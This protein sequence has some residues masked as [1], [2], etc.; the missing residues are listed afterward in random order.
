MRDAYFHRLVAAG[1]WKEPIEEK[2]SESPFPREVKLLKATGLKENSILSRAFDQ[3]K[4]KLLKQL[5]WQ[6]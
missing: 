2:P 4:V 6:L 3:E 5:P 1:L